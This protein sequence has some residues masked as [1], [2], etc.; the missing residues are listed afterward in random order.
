MRVFS[1]C[2]LREPVIDL[3]KNYIRNEC[4]LFLV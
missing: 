1:I 3:I 2:I 4:V